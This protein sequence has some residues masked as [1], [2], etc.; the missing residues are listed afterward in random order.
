MENALIGGLVT[1]Q[2]LKKAPAVPLNEGQ[3][4]KIKTVVVI[5]SAVCAVVMAYITGDLSNTR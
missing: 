1:V 3:R 5:V 2:V 4:G